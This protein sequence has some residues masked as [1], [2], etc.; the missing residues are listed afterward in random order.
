MRRSA[1]SEISKSGGHL[2]AFGRNTFISA[3][4]FKRRTRRPLGEPALE[5]RIGTSRVRWNLPN[6]QHAPPAQSLHVQGTH[7]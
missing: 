1:A 3:H 2:Q 6:V 4:A 5:N 7:H